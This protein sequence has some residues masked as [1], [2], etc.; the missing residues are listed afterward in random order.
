M[1]VEHGITES[2]YGV[3]LVEEQIAIA[4]GSE[5]RFNEENTRPIFTSMQVR[6]NLEDPQDGFTPN[7]GLITR[8]VSTGGPGARMAVRGVRSSW[9]TEEMKSFLSFS[10]LAS[11]SAM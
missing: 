6:V 10:E 11:S 8:Y 1:Q 2:R 5:L 3:D 4:F 7:S 9:D